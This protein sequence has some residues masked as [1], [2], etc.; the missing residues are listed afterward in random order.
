M[1]LSDFM[2]IPAPA[3]SS[4]LRGA[5]LAYFRAQPGRAVW[6]EKVRERLGA[7]GYLIETTNDPD[8]NGFTYK[9]FV[10]EGVHLGWARVRANGQLEFVRKDFATF[11]PFNPAIVAGV[12]RSLYGEDLQ[13][14]AAA[15]CRNCLQVH[16]ASRQIT[17]TSQTRFQLLRFAAE[18]RTITAKM[19]AAQKGF[20][21]RK[22][23]QVSLPAARKDLQGEEKRNYE[24]NRKQQLLEAKAA[25]EFGAIGVVTHPTF[26]TLKKK[27]D[28]KA[29]KQ[30][31]GKV[32][33]AADRAEWRKQGSQT[34][35][36]HPFDE[37]KLERSDVSPTMLGLLTCETGSG[38][39]TYVA[40]SGS[41][42]TQNARFA[43]L[44]RL[45]GYAVCNTPKPPYTTID[46][47]EIAKQL[48]LE[49]K[50]DGAQAA[51]TCA[52]PRLIAQAIKDGV[53]APLSGWHMSEI[54]YWNRGM[55]ESDLVWVPGLTAYSCDT[56][57]KLLPLFFCP[58]LTA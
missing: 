46:G 54:W 18:L 14:Y 43:H 56:C 26:E 50:A 32:D 6:R 19:L 55:P 24:K 10:P 4:E 20:I 41:F 3:V 2:Q 25:A 53:T 34:G 30:L 9:Q 29:E 31:D 23:A 48:Y 51:G 28:G 37:K 45:R 49:S 13:R 38:T 1:K 5:A 47:D 58:E 44:A 52:A 15:V 17:E 8:S 12:P 33:E 21:D 36:P 22:I 40:A 35:Q 57:Q 27:F 11:T 39:K 16:D 42:A 7:T